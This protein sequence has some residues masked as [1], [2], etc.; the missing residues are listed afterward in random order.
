[1][2]R[3]AYVGEVYLKGTHRNSVI[4]LLRLTK[5]DEELRVTREELKEKTARWGTVVIQDMV[6]CH[7]KCN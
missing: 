1:M 5:K 2:S 6:L 4:C 7:T 3:H